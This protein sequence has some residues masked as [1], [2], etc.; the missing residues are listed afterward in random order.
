MTTLAWKGPYTMQFKNVVSAK[1]DA[2]GDSLYP[3]LCCPDVR[4]PRLPIGIHDPL[5]GNEDAGQFQFPNA[6]TGR[7]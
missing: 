1:R 3:F 6:D 7:P 5:V 2:L 4:D